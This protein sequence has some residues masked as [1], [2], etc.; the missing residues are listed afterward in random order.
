MKDIV[1]RLYKFCEES[2]EEIELLKIESMC[3]QKNGVLVSHFDSFRVR[4]NVKCW[5]G[6]YLSVL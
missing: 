3:L 5:R 1:Q 2:V 4:G 6:D